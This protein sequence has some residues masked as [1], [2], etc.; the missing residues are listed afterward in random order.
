[1]SN[2]FIYLSSKE[3]QSIPGIAKLS[4]RRPPL[5]EPS[6]FHREFVAPPVEGQHETKQG[7]SLARESRDTL[8][9]SLDVPGSQTMNIRPPPIFSLGQDD[10]MT[11]TIVRTRTSEVHRRR[12]GFAHE[13]R[14]NKGDC[15]SPP[16]FFS[17]E[18]RKRREKESFARSKCCCAKEN[19]RFP[20]S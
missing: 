20:L 1:M 13:K 6:N 2:P 12:H 15:I 14:V 11:R 18:E 17:R 3:M 16:N 5:W 10:N 9:Q 7:A 19:V 4:P 8:S